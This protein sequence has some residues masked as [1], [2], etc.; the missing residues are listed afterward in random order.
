[1]KLPEGMQT[2]TLI[3]LFVPLWVFYK[4]NPCWY[5][6]HFRENAN[7]VNSSFG[8]ILLLMAIHF[9]SNQLSAISELV[10]TTLGMKIAIRVNS[11][12]RIKQ[13]F[14]Q[15]IFTEQVLAIYSLYDMIQVSLLWA[16]NCLFV[17]F[18]LLLL[19]LFEFLSPL[20]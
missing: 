7:G 19:T 5:F 8:E 13:I 6:F 18:R 17:L 9:H 16:K 3:Y 14:I 4:I 20:I 2:V 15:D 11:M 10:C 1:M 12:T